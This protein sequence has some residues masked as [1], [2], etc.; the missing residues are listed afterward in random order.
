VKRF[1]T[2][3][4]LTIL[5]QIYA[6]LLHLIEKLTGKMVDIEFTLGQKMMSLCRI[7]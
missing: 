4:A 2:L 7:I 1:A 5:V 6:G 3:F